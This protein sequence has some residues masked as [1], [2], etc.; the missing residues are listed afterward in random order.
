MQQF[1]RRKLFPTYYAQ[2]V[3]DVTPAFIRECGCTVV[4]ADIDN[5]LAH[6]D[7]PDAVP[8][9]EAWMQTLKEAGIGLAFLSNND[10]PR[11]EPFAA[12]YGARF[13]CHA[14]KP[15]VKGYLEL[16]K[17]FDCKPEACL[18]VGDQLFTDI[19]GGNNAGMSTV[20]VSP[21]CEAEDPKA[22]RKRRTLEKIL[23]HM[24]KAFQ[25]AKRRIK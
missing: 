6:V 21:I 9:A 22:F 2:A 15:Q 20:I 5:T 11:V 1:S 13:V 19:L 18:V 17:Q 8:M 12:K 14:Q 24:D 23:L 10:P 7:A 16:A 25:G 3:T 4:L